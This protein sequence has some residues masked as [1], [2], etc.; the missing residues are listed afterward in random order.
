MIEMLVVTIILLIVVAMSFPSIESFIFTSKERLEEQK[1]AE[2]AE[3]MGRYAR[4]N[5]ELPSEI[6][7]ANGTWWEKLAEYSELSE[8]EILIDE[9]DNER[10]YLRVTED[11]NFRDGE[12][13]VSYGIVYGYG[14]SGCLGM[15]DDCR[16]NPTP[17]NTFGVD[18][19]STPNDF[20]TLQASVG[21]FMARYADH[22]DKIEAYKTTKLRLDKISD[23]LSEYS[24]RV[25]N[26]AIVAG[27]TTYLV[28]GVNYVPV[29]YPPNDIAY[30]VNLYHPIVRSELSVDGV[31][32]LDDGNGNA[33]VYSGGGTDLTNLRRYQSMISLM[34]F[35]G[36]P[37][38]YCCSA[39]EVFN[40]NGENRDMPFYY[41][42]NPRQ[43]NG[44]ICNARPNAS[45]AKL[46]ARL[47]TGGQNELGVCG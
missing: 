34:R 18:D 3:A 45:A 44:A 39:L 47:T 46:P 14:I 41:Y 42:S 20:R 33:R 2:I 16:L 17:L 9:W 23:A 38:E 4:H 6:A 21:D 30:D 12:Y 27:T 31:N 1:M 26:E 5:R 13:V 32:I 43:R 11:A 19:F 40:D 15:S 28:G 10:V 37:D 29:F 22:A 35:L 25:Y 7:D 24:E 36:L 8:E